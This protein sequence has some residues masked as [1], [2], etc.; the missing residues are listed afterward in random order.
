MGM[1]VCYMFM[2]AQ[3][4]EEVRASVTVFAGGCEPSNGCWEPNF[5]TLEE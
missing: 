1:Y 2:V 4:P 5:G 3:T